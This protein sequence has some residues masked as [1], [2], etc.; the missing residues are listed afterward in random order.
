MAVSPKLRQSGRSWRKGA[1]RGGNGG[2]ARGRGGRG[3]K[4]GNLA[5]RRG[6]NTV[7]L[8]DLGLDFTDPSVATP[9][10]AAAART[11]AS[12]TL[13][14]TP[15]SCTHSLCFSPA[16]ASLAQSPQA[17]CYLGATSPKTSVVVLPP[18]FQSGDASL[19]RVAG[20]HVAASWAAQGSDASRRG[21]PAGQV[22]P[23]AWSAP[24]PQGWIQQ[25]TQLAPAATGVAQPITP[26]P[27]FPPHNHGAV[28][29][30]IPQPRTPP[31]QLPPCPPAAGVVD[32]QSGS[33]E[34]RYILAAK[35][36]AAAPECY[37]D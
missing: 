18:Q 37:E 36:R 29:S 8:E 14:Q 5:Q 19:R 11:P 22:S 6:L 24:G 35:L 20:A 4:K 27:Q 17:L 2:N 31:P 34:W 33:M 13:P 28:F 9:Q 12:A 10:V 1:P 15:A 25:A 32:S 23:A 30:A 16:F 26:P 3:G 7:L 21:P